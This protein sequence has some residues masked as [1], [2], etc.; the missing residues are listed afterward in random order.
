[1]APRPPRRGLVNLVPC[2]VGRRRR[3]PPALPSSAT[4]S[5]DAQAPDAKPAWRGV[6]LGAR[7]GYSLPAGTLSSAGS[8][9]HLSNLETASV[10]IGIDA[11]YRFSHAVY[12]GGTLAWGPGIA[13]NSRSTCPAPASCFRQDAQLRLDV[14]LYT[15][16][17]ARGAWWF[18]FGTGWEVAAFSEGASGNSETATLTGPVLADLQAG[19]EANRSTPLISPFFGMAIA[20]FLTQG[21][22]PAHGQVSTWIPDPGIHLW[23]TLGLRGEFGPW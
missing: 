21:Q 14:R 4:P 3:G 22:N 16:P 18:G 15:H 19:F 17:R 2:L 12:V 1:M 9:T 8:S 6:Q 23:F 7:L 10:P 20:E 5:V 11:G 13:P